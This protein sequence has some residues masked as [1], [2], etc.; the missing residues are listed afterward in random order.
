MDE[1][2]P[3]IDV[4]F[5]VRRGATPATHFD[6]TR[7]GFP[8]TALYLDQRGY[9]LVPVYLPTNLGDAI[10]YLDALS[11]AVATLRAQIVEHVSANSS[12]AA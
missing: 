12:E 4:S 10:S 5:N 9:N 2:I 11:A 3:A 8:L 6:P 1:D 7:Y